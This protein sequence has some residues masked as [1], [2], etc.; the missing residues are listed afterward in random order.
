LST[1]LNAAEIW[2]SMQL[3]VSISRS[4]KAAVNSPYDEQRVCIESYVTNLSLPVT[5][6]RH[7]RQTHLSTQYGQSNINMLLAQGFMQMKCLIRIPG[8]G[9]SRLYS[10][11]RRLRK[12]IW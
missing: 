4:M 11:L 3:D 1:R 6:N 10:P 9:L 5:G 12:C 8:S 2:C 7:V